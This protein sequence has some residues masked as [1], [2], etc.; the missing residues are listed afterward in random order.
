MLA[1]ALTGIDIKITLV[2]SPEIGTVGVGE[3]TIPPIVDVLSFLGIDE[4]DFVR[5]TQATFKLGIR[6]ADW[7]RPGLSY[8][9]PFGTF[10]TPVAGRPFHHAWHAARAA[11]LPV[12]LEDASPC[13]ALA[14]QGLFRRPD[15]RSPGMAAGLRYAYHFDAALVA[16]YLEA[17]ATRLG[18]RHLARTIT[19]ATRRSDGTVDELV[20][21]D[22]SR[23]AADFYLD[24]S[25]F[26][27]LLIEQTLGTGWVDWR[28]FL[29]CDRALAMP[30]M[31]DGPRPPYTE[32]QALGAGWRWRIPLQ[33]RVGNG[34]VYS[35]SHLDDAAAAEALLGAA[36]GRPLA[37]PRLLRFAAG[38]RRAF[39]NGN[40]FALGLAGGFL[41][42][43]ES[44]SIHLVVSAVW[45]LLEHFP[46]RDFAPENV[47]ASNAELGAEL[48]RIRDFIVLH[49]CLTERTDTPFWRDCRSLRLPD[50]LVERIE[51]YRATGR[52]RPRSW[53]L[54]TDASW[55]YVFEG[56][57]LVPDRTD[58]LLAAVPRA[59]LA[60]ILARLAG[61]CH[62]VR[63]G[64]RPHDAWFAPVADR[65][66]AP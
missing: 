59:R 57:G 53:E 46:D 40:V 8:W 32:S 9:H 66:V 21:A 5:H 64:A 20:A 7:R 52:V 63:S 48:E 22:G 11:G 1:R 47:A 65:A 25:G 17:Y 16:R 39:W 51:L 15:P 61:A 55:F 49:Y 2:E 36:P 28:E 19:G 13:A 4:A 62:E 45:N 42:P 35:S 27:A 6:F 41:E 34:Y 12:R 31:L 18:V 24:C 44:T 33:H 37:E 30:T 14:E 50:T 23:I 54:F 29:P 3:A 60:E 56:L 10:G 38:R 43:L 26:R 58:P